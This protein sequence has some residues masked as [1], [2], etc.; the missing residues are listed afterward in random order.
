MA[1]KIGKV[2]DY[3]KANRKGSRDAELELNNGFMRKHAIHKSKK[4]Y[5]RKRNKKLCQSY[6]K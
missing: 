1:K 4:A 2:S 3:V 6:G 5:D